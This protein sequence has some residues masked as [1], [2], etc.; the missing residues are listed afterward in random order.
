[1]EHLL[2]RT[3]ATGSPLHQQDLHFIKEMVLHMAPTFLAATVSMRTL[4]FHQPIHA[5]CS[6]TTSLWK[7]GTLPINWD[8]IFMMETCY[9]V[10]TKD[11]FLR[12]RRSSSC[13]STCLEF[14]TSPSSTCF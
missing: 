3:L 4:Q 8:V 11:L 14:L 13:F 6:A 5:G 10:P 1:M 12:T 7:M 9:S 2:A